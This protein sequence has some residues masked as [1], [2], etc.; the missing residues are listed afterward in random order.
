MPQCGGE[1][2]EKEGGES[3]D[4][5]S[6]HV[7]TGLNPSCPA[8]LQSAATPRLTLPSARAA[9]YSSMLSSNPLP[10]RQTRRTRPY[11]SM[12]SPTPLPTRQTR[13][14]RPIPTLTP[15]VLSHASFNAQQYT[16]LLIV[17]A[18]AS[19][20]RFKALVDTGAAVNLISPTLV[21]S[22]GLLLTPLPAVQPV[23]LADRSSS[24]FQ[25]RHHVRI[26]FCLPTLCRSWTISALVC[27]TGSTEMILGL[28][29][30][31]AN[32]T[33]VDW[34]VP[35]LVDLACS[36]P[37][38][39]PSPC[40]SASAIRVSA[41]HAPIT[42]GLTPIDAFPTA[43]DPPDYLAY[44]RRTVPPGYHDL[45]AAFS[46]SAA[47]S[48]PRDRGSL[49]H[50]IEV[51]PGSR[52]PAERVRPASLPK[53]A[54][55]KVWV[56][57]ML[58]KGFIRRSKS[59]YGANLTS[60][61]KP[62][63]SIRWCIDYRRL[64]AIT[65][66]DKTPLPLISESLVLL[67]RA[68][69]F[70]RF[71]L[72]SAFN[73]VVMDPDSVDKTAF[74]TREGL[75]ECLVM[76][77]GLTNAV[78]TFQRLVNTALHGLI[79]VVCVVYLDDIIVFSE[80][81][82]KHAGHV[83]RV[84]ERLV[85]HG[86][87][88]KAEKCEFSVSTTKFL[89]HTISPEGISMDSEQVSAIMSFPPP[90]SQRELSRFI[91]LA[92]AYRRYIKD[93]AQLAR[94]LNALLR[95]SS[96]STTPFLSDSALAAFRR[97]RSVFA[98]PVVLRHFDASLPT[99]VETDSSGFA[100]AAILSQLHP[101]GYRPVAYWSR[102]TTDV[103]RRYGAHD[104]EL[105]AVVEATRHW[106]TLL[107]SCNDSFTIYTDHQ[108]LQYFQTS[109]RLL[110]RHVR[111]SQ[112]LNCHSYRI[113]YRPA[114]EN[115]KAD[116]LSRRS[117][118]DV[119]LQPIVEPILRPVEVLAITS[120]S[121]TPSADSPTSSNVSSTQLMSRIRTACLADSALAPPRPAHFSVPGQIPV[122][123]HNV[124]YVPPDHSLRSTVLSLAHDSLAVGH[125]GRD[126][127]T[128]LVRRVY[129]WPG[130]PADV[131]RYVSSCDTCQKSKASHR[132]PQ[133]FLKPLPVANRPWSSITW[134]YIG[135]LPSSSNGLSTFDAILVI[136]DRFTK[137]AHFVPAKTTDDSRSLARH[138]LHNVFRPHGLPDHIISDRGSTFASSWWRE[139]CMLLGP[140]IRLST[141][142]H[143]QTDG[144]TERTNQS[145]E[146]YLRCFVDYLQTDWS[147]LLDTAEFA[148]NNA[149][150]SATSQSPFFTSY[151]FHPLSPLD[152]SADISS[153]RSSVP[154]AKQLAA[155]LVESHQIAKSAL[156]AAAERMA[157][158]SRSRRSATPT[159]KVDDF[160]LVRSDHIHTTRPSKKLDD[161]NIGPFRITHVLGSHNYRLDLG[162]RKIHNVFHVDRLMPY[163]SPASFPGRPRLARPPPDTAETNAYEVDEI[164]DSRR[165]RRKLEYF[166][167][168]KGYGNED[169]QWVS[170]SD[171]DH[172]DSL[173]LVFSRLHPTK[174]VPAATRAVT[175]TAEGSYDTVM[176]NATPQIATRRN[177][178]DSSKCRRLALGT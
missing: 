152:Q 5:C 30:I 113:K 86:L 38:P 40:S 89:G 71:D 99:V 83:R 51:L 33:I 141:A 60:A 90:T 130:L 172:D 110:P 161:K 23:I 111:W 138:F 100:I 8:E 34:A 119:P 121:S 70:T 11:S 106:T 164:V 43:N 49:N 42:E 45:L 123:Y 29:W 76:P 56:D 157:S 162:A 118:F 50:S 26:R 14:T 39:M 102:Q 18:T 27:P 66:K 176:D 31:K 124:V 160:V 167:R 116:A 15:I 48:L 146:H 61:S 174:P 7:C 171:F 133:G 24:A 115:C 145:V 47:D 75:F 137:L 165:L 65:T 20:Y 169:M 9:L 37:L 41:A 52:P 156:A 173:V 154:D 96:T 57:D 19:S 129:N 77:F 155:R 151:G 6:K 44:L 54:S 78:A 22:L 149:R 64:N 17:D 114:R 93:F 131:R 82:S 108:A 177:Q 159:F 148:Y 69:L 98:S 153:L 170:A 117:D 28:P 136:V 35:C 72:R 91:G 62:D 88:I 3:L 2:G 97:L 12:L 175:D 135:P 147:T 67:G 55:Q 178:R 74:V 105:L 158:S 142:F 128:D 25:V 87:F 80:D 120:A 92:N 13:Q 94:P 53:L 73:Q 109:Q 122:L 126:R 10:T 112:D 79:D 16:D 4:L 144:Q 95:K 101:D 32:S 140:E 139:F 59:P 150:H 168:W 134:D 125:P 46:K 103:E 104:S 1:R 85:E 84:L 143:P 127:T 166:V 81:S 163:I 68:Q 21:E 63:G 107:E 36:R 132:R 58:R